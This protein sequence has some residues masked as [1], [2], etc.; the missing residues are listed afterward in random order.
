MNP[1]LAFR[2]TARAAMEFYQ[3]VFGGELNVSSYADIPAMETDPS[4]AHKVM[5]SMLVADNGI[6]LMAGDMPNAMDDAPLNGSISLSGDDDATLRGYFEKLSA[7]GEITV[8]LEQAPWG[9]SF[10]Q[11][12]DKFGINWMVNIAGLAG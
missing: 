2:D 10:G 5:H 12:T 8:P 6:V 3:S 11:L 4:E 9:D 1:Y 7:G